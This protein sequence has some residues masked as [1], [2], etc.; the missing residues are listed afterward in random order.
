MNEKVM[1]VGLCALLGMGSVA[2]ADTMLRPR[3]VEST[4]QRA[5]GGVDVALDTKNPANAALDSKKA[6][7]MSLFE[8]DVNMSISEFIDVYRLVPDVMDFKDTMGLSDY[9]LDHKLTTLRGIIDRVKFDLDTRIRLEAVRINLGSPKVGR[10][11]FGAYAE[12]EVGAK[13]RLPEGLDE[14]SLVFG[15]DG[16]PKHI[17]IGKD[18]DVLQA[19]G[20]ADAGG[21]LSYGYGGMSLWKKAKLAAGIQA[22]GFHRWLV[23][24]YTIHFKKEMKDDKDIDISDFE[25]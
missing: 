1:V 15:K 2:S 4:E 25:C 16:K 22:K 21:F 5:M 11:Q 12:S 24:M 13:V 7:Y 23:P 9:S 18:M 17:D 6:F 14:S 10:F 20:R 3:K 19:K 8:S